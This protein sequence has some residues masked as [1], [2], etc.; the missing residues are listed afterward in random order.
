MES[1]LR[2]TLEGKTIF[3][4]K[5]ILSTL[6]ALML[7]YPPA[8]AKEIGRASTD[9]ET[10]KILAEELTM[11]KL[12]SLSVII[13]ASSQHKEGFGE[14]LNFDARM[15]EHNHGMLVK[16]RVTRV[17]AGE[18]KVEGVKLHMPGQWEFKLKIKQGQKE[19]QVTIPYLL[20]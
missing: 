17:K 6:A 8:V 10:I 20:P 1:L 3:I 15:P 19:N 12:T 11:N 18:F 16:P 5:L 13:E 4:V 2:T 7:F 9:G 14:L